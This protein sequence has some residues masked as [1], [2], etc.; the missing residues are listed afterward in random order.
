MSATPS[1]VTARISALA[2]RQHAVVTLDQARAAGM[3]ERAVRGWAKRGIW[4]REAPRLYRMAGAPRTWEARAMAAVLSIG[5]DCL[6]SHRTAGHLWLS[7]HLPAPGRIEVTVPLG[8]GRQRR[9]GLTVHETRAW[10]LVDRRLRT[11]V[12]V[13]GPARTLL[14]LCAVLDDLGALGVL[15]EMRRRRLVTWEELWEALTLHQPGRRG[16]ARYRRILGIRNGRR[17]PHTTFARLF[18]RLLDRAGLPAPE[19][20]QL[21]ALGRGV[22]YRVDAA[23]VDRRIAIELDGKESHQTEKAFEGD[24]VRDNRLEIDGWVVLRYTWRRFTTEPDE[25]VAE[26][27]AALATRAQP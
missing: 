11:L 5:G 7:D 3:S 8:A 21:V 14:D 6:A 24:R 9:P 1:T 10:D 20:E 25:I 15:D 23:Y 4:T 2:A 27:R 13:T 17:V 22:R 26:V 12:P 16:R 19:S 18:L